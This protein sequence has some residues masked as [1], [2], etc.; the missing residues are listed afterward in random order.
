MSDSAQLIQA[1]FARAI[2]M[3]EGTSGFG[4]GLLGVLANGADAGSYEV[5]GVQTADLSVPEPERTDILGND[6][7]LAAFTWKLGA[8]PSGSIECGVAD[9]D[10]NVALEGVKKYESD[11]LEIAPLGADTADPK[12]AWL[13]CQNRAVDY[14][15]GYRGLG[16]KYFI[17]VPKMSAV[18]I[19]P[20]AIQQRQANTSRLRMTVQVSDVL[21]WGEA[22]TLSNLGALSALMFYGA[23]DY[24]WD[25]HSFIGDG[26]TVDVVLDRTPVDDNSGTVKRTA[27]WVDGV[28]AV[29]VTDFVVVPA[30]KTVTFQAGHIP[31]AGAEVGIR[32]E[33]V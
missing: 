21:P 7:L 11:G 12:D 16:K 26:T 28:K 22:V 14:E 32:Y 24:Y 17:I 8:S 4:R 19:G 18:V 33:Y 27:I 29:P 25:M 31:T 9:L 6:M 2:L 13:I 10:L 23:S 15:T 20:S 5:L 3:R 30:T 1:G